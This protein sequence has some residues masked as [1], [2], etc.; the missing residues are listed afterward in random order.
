M[1]DTPVHKIKLNDDHLVKLSSIFFD[2]KVDSILT[3]HLVN[4]VIMDLCKS[5]L[6]WSNIRCIKGRVNNYKTIELHYNSDP[7]RDRHLFYGSD[8][9]SDSKEGLESLKNWSAVIY[10]DDS[11]FKYIDGSHTCTCVDHSREVIVNIPAGTILLFPSTTIHQALKSDISNCRRTIVIFDI[12]NPDDTQCK[13]RIVICPKWT[14][15]SILYNF[16]SIDR[17]H[18]YLINSLSLNNPY[19]YRYVPKTNDNVQRVHWQITNIGGNEL[20]PQYINYNT[21]IYFI[22]SKDK[23]PVQMEIIRPYSYIYELIFNHLAI[24]SFKRSAAVGRIPHP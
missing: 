22:D 6:E 3:K 9:M 4:S 21:S 11:N 1:N 7:H 14:Q 18:E 8:N 15:N 16:I 20:Q 17:A 24:F 10:L 13:H 2:T 23:Y 12:E 5:K 19:F